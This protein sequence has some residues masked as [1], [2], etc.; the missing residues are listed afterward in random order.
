MG[1]ETLRHLLPPD[2]KV[3]SLGEFVRTFAPALVI[4]T[5][6]LHIDTPSLLLDDPQP[7]VGTAPAAAVA[8]TKASVTR[9][10]QW[11]WNQSS[12]R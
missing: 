3:Y 10:L 11:S 5:G 1:S 6:V 4:T 7:E 2:Q 9:T 12:R 8:A